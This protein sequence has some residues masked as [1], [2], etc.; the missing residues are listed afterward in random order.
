M[1]VT[2]EGF[3]E[4]IGNFDRMTSPRDEVFWPVR[5]AM[6][7][8]VKRIEGAAKENLTS[9]GSVAFGQLRASTAA[10]GGG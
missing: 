9:N 10:T 3:D 8:V 7:S 2:I 4:V 6:E 5:D 1:K